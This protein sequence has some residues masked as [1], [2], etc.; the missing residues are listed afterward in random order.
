MLQSQAML[1]FFKTI[2]YEPLYNALVF[3]I[4]TIPGGDVGLAIIILTLAVKLVLAPLSQKSI[5]SQARLK[6]L[7]PE[8]QKI[9]EQYKNKEEQAKKTFE[10][11]KTNKVNP[12][13]GCLLVLIQLPIIISLF[14][15]FLNGLSF[16]QGGIYSFIQIPPIIN[17]EFLGLVDMQERSLVLALLA[18][19]SQY[20][21]FKFAVPKLKPV[22]SNSKPSFKDNLMK[23]MN[24][25]MRYFM[26]VFIGI[27]AYQVSAAVA[28]YWVTS[29]LFIIGQEIFVRR[30]IRRDS[31]LPDSQKTSQG[32]QITSL[33]AEVSAK[34]GESTN[35]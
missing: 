22:S 32:G 21:Q 29:N 4:D 31:N 24:L 20:F 15:V 23:S 7:E 17:F 35:S 2:F 19:L 26:P 6:T 28:L 13:S 9:K 10:L 5:K 27:I 14:Y 34:A 16:D 12:F 30:K 1:E 18:A 33:P 3:L 25:N 11:Y 8:I